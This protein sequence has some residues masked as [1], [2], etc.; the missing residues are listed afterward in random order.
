MLRMIDRHYSFWECIT[1][2]EQC[3]IRVLSKYNVK[4]NGLMENIMGRELY[5]MR[6]GVSIIHGNGTMVI[7]PINALNK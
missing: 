6:I 2:K 1:E 4:M 5:I 7:M 3:I